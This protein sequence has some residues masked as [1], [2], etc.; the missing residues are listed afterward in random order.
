MK[1]TTEPLSDGLGQSLLYKKRDNPDSYGI[2]QG[3]ER[4]MERTPLKITPAPGGSNRKMDRNLKLTVK[5]AHPEKIHGDKNTKIKIRKTG[6]SDRKMQEGGLNIGPATASMHGFKPKSQV[7]N[8]H[9][10]IT[11]SLKM[12]GLREMHADGAK[13]YKKRSAQVAGVTGAVGGAI[14]G[15]AGV[16]G[17]A[18]SGFLIGGPTGAVAGGTIGGIAGAGAGHALGDVGGRA[19]AVPFYASGALSRFA[20]DAASS[21]RQTNVKLNQEQGTL[22][23]DGKEGPKPPKGDGGLK[24]R[25]KDQLSPSLAK[26]ASLEQQMIRLI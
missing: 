24:P 16:A 6:K 9:Q 11:H 13:N 3:P 25:K 4:G 10:T 8:H 2:G 23:T 5:P 7:N 20:I 19:L 12:A 26:T 1:V 18:G 21:M 14:G 22:G 17:G 15:A